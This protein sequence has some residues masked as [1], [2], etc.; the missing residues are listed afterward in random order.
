MA[1]SSLHASHSTPRSGLCTP[2]NACAARSRERGLRID[3]SA[4]FVRSSVPTRCYFTIVS[5]AN[6]RL[7]KPLTN[8]KNH[9]QNHKQKRQQKFE[10]H[11]RNH[12]QILAKTLRCAGD[13][14]TSTTDCGLIALHC[15]TLGTCAR[16]K[17]VVRRCM[18]QG[19]AYVCRSRISAC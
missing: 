4:R 10:N 18:A 12:K 13:G 17:A 3:H 15:L 6:A 19:L 1:L 2:Y 9:K 7:W 11:K 8:P 14:I 16:N 5:T